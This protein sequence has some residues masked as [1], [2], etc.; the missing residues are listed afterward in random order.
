MPV[1][2]PPFSPGFHMVNGATISMIFTNAA[3]DSPFTV[4]KSYCG[5]GKICDDVSIVSHETDYFTNKWDYESWFGCQFV[6]PKAQDV[7]YEINPDS[8]ETLSISLPCLDL[9]GD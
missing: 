2:F 8:P 6:D 1:E 9:S 4:D 7:T 3:T 5:D